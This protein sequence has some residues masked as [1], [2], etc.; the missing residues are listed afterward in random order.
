MLRRALRVVPTVL[1][2]VT[3]AGCVAAD[4]TVESTAHVEVVA[5]KSSTQCEG[6]KRRDVRGAKPTYSQKRLARFPNRSLLCHGIWL[7]DPRRYLVPQGIAISGNTAWLSGFRHRKGFGKRPCQLVRVD[8]VTGR[9][10]QFHSAIFGRVGDRPR[11]Y[12]RHGGGILQRG[13]WL[14]I[15]EKNKLW[16]VNPA[17]PGS[18]LNARRAWRIHAPVRGSAIVATKTRIGLVPFQIGGVAR[19]YWYDIQSLIRPGVL[20]LAVRRSG[21]S[22]IGAVASTRIPRFTQGATL[23]SRGRLYLTRSNLSCGELVTP[24]GRR[25]A[26]IPGAEGIQFAARDQRLWAVS[27]SGSWPYSLLG[28]PLTPAVA[29]FEWPRLLAGEGRSCDFPAY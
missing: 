23:D 26:F 25:K 29:S 3:S 7:P 10:L 9:R 27:E 21:R 11:T 8:L 1:L 14:W 15:V 4:R 28:K 22:Q 19:I 18:V 12:C 2:L 24:F 5:A 16:I 13:K 17:R 20:D 6:L